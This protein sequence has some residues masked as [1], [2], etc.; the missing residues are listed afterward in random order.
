MSK[1]NRAHRERKNGKFTQKHPELPK[2]KSGK[3]ASRKAYAK[4]KKVKKVSK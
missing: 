3:F 1:P 2:G 4:A